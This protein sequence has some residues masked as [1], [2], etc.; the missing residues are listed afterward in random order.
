MSISLRDS[1]YKTVRGIRVSR[2]PLQ[3]P[4]ERHGI[5]IK[6][7]HLEPPFDHVSSPS[8][9]R[10][11]VTSQCWFLLLFRIFF[12]IW[13]YRFHALSCKKNEK[14]LQFSCTFMSPHHRP[15]LT[16]FSYHVY[17]TKQTI[18]TDY[19]YESTDDIVLKDCK[20]SRNTPVYCKIYYTLFI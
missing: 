15:L 3:L 10:G 11:D 14:T 1:N 16:K 20:Q 19:E 17:S 6:T 4:A 18:Y 8:H 12:S 13:S 5:L 7:W 9:F 2:E